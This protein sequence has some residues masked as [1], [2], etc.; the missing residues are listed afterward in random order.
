MSVTPPTCRVTLAYTID[1]DGI[2]LWCMDPEHGDL[3]TIGFD[4]TPSDAARRAAA[5]VA[6]AAGTNPHHFDGPTHQPHGAQVQVG[7]LG[8]T[9]AFYAWWEQPLGTT[10]GDGRE[11]GGISPVY[12]D[13]G[14]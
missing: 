3:G 9:G 12:A 2:H 10:M 13:R 8:Q 14:E 11:G 5:H 6:E 1:D 7:W 4:P